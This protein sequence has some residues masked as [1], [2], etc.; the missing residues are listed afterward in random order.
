VTSAASVRTLEVR[1]LQLARAA[2]AAL[3][4]IMVTFSS[5]HSAAVGLGIFSGFGVATAL[6]LAVAAWLVYPTGSRWPSIALAVIAFA[7]ALAASI[8]AWRTTTGFFVI[9]IAWALASGLVETIAAIRAR[10]DAASSASRDGATIGILTLVLGI[11]LLFVR[12]D[13]ALE[14]YIEDAGRSFT[15]T[16]ITIAVG[17][18]GAYAAIVAVF[19]AI[20]GFS[21]RRVPAAVASERSAS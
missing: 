10:K 7:A 4:A 9:V 2:F 15:L 1:H 13:Y 18:F 17:I 16:G 8:G 14:Y 6:V 3:A 21:P 19:L 5:D 20:A 12:P 11:A